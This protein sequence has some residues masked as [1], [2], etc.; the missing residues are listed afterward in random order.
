MSYGS[1][2][3]R[4]GAVSGV[5]DA[6][7]LSADLMVA[8]GVGIATLAAIILVLCCTKK[9]CNIE[10]QGKQIMYSSDIAGLAPSNTHL[11]HNTDY[12][13]E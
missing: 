10:L 7:E 4:A 5:I 9:D 1:I 11:I 12:R 2:R 13:R 8:I 6:E 3:I